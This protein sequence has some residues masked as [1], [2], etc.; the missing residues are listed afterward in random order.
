MLRFSLDWW[1]SMGIW[2]WP[3][4]LLVGI[5]IGLSLVYEAVPPGWTNHGLRTVGEVRV[6]LRSRGRIEPGEPI[7]LMLTASEAARMRFGFD[8][9]QARQTPRA[10]AVDLP[11]GEGLQLTVAAPAQTGAPL[12]AV[13]TDAGGDAARWNLGRLYD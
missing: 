4:L 6:G 7:Q 12:I 9:A 11:A 10:L 3:N 8:A 1:R 5:A 2:G 13:L